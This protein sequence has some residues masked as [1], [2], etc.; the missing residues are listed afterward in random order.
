ML[1]VGG[2]VLAVVLG[3]M[4]MSDS[5]RSAPATTAQLEPVDKALGLCEA[6]TKANS[7]FEVG[8]FGQEHEIVGA[9]LPANHGRVSIDYRSKGDGLLMTTTCE[10]STV[11][12]ETVLVKAKSS[13]K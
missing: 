12:G 6:W 9:K 5:P 13:L 1:A 8:T 3:W 11:Q 7:K 4:A 10:Y 2:V